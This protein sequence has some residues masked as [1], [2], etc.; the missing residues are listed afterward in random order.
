MLREILGIYSISR[1][2]TR[3]TPGIYSIFGGTVRKKSRDSQHFHKA[4]L[5]KILG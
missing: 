1:R 5:Q 4:I 3:T 2:M